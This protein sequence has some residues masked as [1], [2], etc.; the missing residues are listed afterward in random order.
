MPPAAA[1]SLS[2]FSLPS[3][4]LLRQFPRAGIFACVLFLAL[5]TLPSQAR[6]WGCEGHQV[7]ALLAEKHLT[8]HALAMAKRILADSP[9]DPTLS[10][11][12]KEGSTDPDRK[13][14]V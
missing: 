14:V 9:I 12:C 1:S 11:Y 5:V 3:K 2:I 4:S 6:A 10:R 13:S 8:Q 7:I